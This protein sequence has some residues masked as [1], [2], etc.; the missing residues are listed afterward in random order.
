MADGENREISG[1]IVGPE[2][3][4]DETA[5][6]GVAAHFEEAAK[7][8]PA[9]ATRTTAAPT[10]REA[11]LE[12]EGRAGK[13]ARSTLTCQCSLRVFPPP[14]PLVPA[15]PRPP[16]ARGGGPGGRSAATDLRQRV[17]LD[18]LDHLDDLE[19]QSAGRR[20]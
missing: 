12:N 13:R 3:V 14:G 15:A 1:G 8:R 6:R 5:G 16:G 19:Q 20:V 9:L 7:E 2:R 10:A 18:P 17:A 4:E 11:A